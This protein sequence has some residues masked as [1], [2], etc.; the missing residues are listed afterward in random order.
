MSGSHARNDGHPV[1]GGHQEPGAAVPVLMYHWVHPDPG[2]RLRLY[3]VTPAAFAWQ[4]RHLHAAGYRT[5]G[6]DELQDHLAGRKPLGERRLVL[7]FDDGYVDNVELAGPILSEVGFSATSFIVTDRAGEVNAWDSAHGDAPRPLLDWNAMRRHDGGIFTFEPHSRTHPN[8]TEIDPQRARDE[9][10]AS[11][12][13]LE[14]ELGRRATVFAYPHGARNTHLD[15]LSKEAGYTAAVTDRQGRNRPG[16]DPFLIRR[17]M[18]T[19]R[20]ILPT[21]AFKVMTGYG[22]YGLGNALLRQVAGSPQ[23]G[24]QE[25][26]A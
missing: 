1:S 22:V 11:G 5:A 7:T 12:R 21:Y 16:D 13:R 25:H 6:L 18:I 20:D 19:S 2:D 9:I 3:G 26:A 24:E 10:A 23:T 8:L 15:R 17:T 4:M 14:D